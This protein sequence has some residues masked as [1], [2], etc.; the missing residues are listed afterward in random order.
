MQSPNGSVLSSSHNVIL[1]I[2][3]TNSKIACNWLIRAGVTLKPI[4]KN[5][6]KCIE[7]QIKSFIRKYKSDIRHLFGKYT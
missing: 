2:R 7:K 4:Q 1:V 6:L 3:L 5:K